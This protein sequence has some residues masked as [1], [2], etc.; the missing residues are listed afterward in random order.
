MMAVYNCKLFFFL[1]DLNSFLM[2][3]PLIFRNSTEYKL[4]NRQ[5]KLAT[6]RYQL[7]QKLHGNKSR[8]LNLNERIV[9]RVSMCKF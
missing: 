6:A 5:F 4:F 7:F 1:L 2:Y 3:V 9:L 8:Y